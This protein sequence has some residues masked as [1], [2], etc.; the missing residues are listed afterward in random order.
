MV[1]TGRH[2]RCREPSPEEVAGC[3]HWYNSSYCASQGLLVNSLTGVLRTLSRKS[4]VV[5]LELRIVNGVS[6][7]VHVVRRSRG[8]SMGSFGQDF[9]ASC[10]SLL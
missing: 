4:L 3:E 5:C 7:L 6:G 8:I 2:P 10:A 9:F 1:C